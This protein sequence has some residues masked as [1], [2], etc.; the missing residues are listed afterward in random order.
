MNIGSL[1]LPE[2]MIWAA[3]MA[4]ISDKACRIINKEFG[5]VLVFTEM[6][7]DKG[8]LYGQQR[9]LALLNLEGEEGPAA[10]Q[11]F[12]REP[13][14]LGQAALIAE[15][16]G[17][18]LIDINCGCP[19]PK[20]VKNGAGAA[21]MREPRRC[22]E[23]FR[24]V[25]R[26]VKIPVTVKMR[27]GWDE[28]SSDRCVEIAGLAEQEG[29]AAVIIHPRTREQFFSGKA[30]WGKVKAVKQRISIP[31]I[32]NGDIDSGETARFRLETS[33]C[34]GIMIGRAYLGNPFIFREINGFL[35][36]KEK[37]APVTWA[38][39]LETAAKHLNLACLFKGE[40]VAV[41]EMRKHI[42]WYCKGIP[43]A[44][45][46]RAEINKAQTRAQMLECLHS[47][48]A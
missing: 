21:L 26:A 6:V 38:E 8:L 34:D 32:G 42:S 24:T 14:Q 20:I 31:V 19:T 27:S 29:A 35:Q 12:G 13:E 48:F 30:D 2:P 10:V 33:G 45:K 37:T 36:N 43:G 3:P 11:I 25:V 4:G 15:N 28:E 46:K 22:R 18:A 9:T 44:A 40:E 47:A 23:I 7:N 41:K 17:A 5:C 39:R 1:S 16:S